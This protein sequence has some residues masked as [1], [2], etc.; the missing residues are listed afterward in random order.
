MLER[1]GQGRGDG[2]RARGSQSSVVCV[3]WVPFNNVNVLG[4]R[5]EDS[6]LINLIEMRGWVRNLKA[7]YRGKKV[8]VWWSGGRERGPLAGEHEAGEPRPG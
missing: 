8:E 7:I 5:Q 4:W 1:E 6:S 2:K 3:P